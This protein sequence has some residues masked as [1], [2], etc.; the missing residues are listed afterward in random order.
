MEKGLMVEQLVNHY[1]DGNKAMFARILGVQH[2]LRRLDRA[3]ERVMQA[4]TK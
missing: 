1:T 3:N 2:D 4:V